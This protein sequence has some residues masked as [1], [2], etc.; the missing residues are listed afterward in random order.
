MST[1][2]YTAAKGKNTLTCDVVI[3]GS[4]PGGAAAARTLAEGG[5]KVIVLEEGPAK[6]NF[7]P[8][9]QHTMRYHM[10]E[11][12]QMLAQGDLIF[13]V[14]AG[15]GVGG[16]SL[17]NSAICWR[18]PD[19]V[20]R[21]WIP[22]LNGDDRYSPEHLA[23]IYEELEALLGIADTPEE[24]WGENNAIVI[25][26]ANALGLN[27]RPLKRNTPGCVG[28]GICN[29]GCPSGGKA[30]VDRNLI[31]MAIAAGAI[32][33]GDVKV[34]HLL[35][36]D[37]KMKGVSGTVRN[38]DSEEVVGELTILADIVIVAAG[39]IGS[40]RLFHHTGMAHHLGPACGQNLHLHPGNAVFGLCDHEVHMW[41]GATQGAYF[42][43]PELPEILPHTISLDPGALLLAMGGIGAQAKEMM[44]LLPRM[45]GCLVMVTDKGSGSVGSTNDGRASITYWWDEDDIRL[46]KLG[47]L[48][49]AEVLVAGGAKRLLVP[50]HG[51]GWV[52]S[53]DELRE[54]MADKGLRDFL[55]MYS[56]HPTGTCHMGVDPET[57]VVRPDG[58][59]HHIEGLYI[60]DSSLFPSALGVNP[61]LT[62]MAMATVIAKGILANG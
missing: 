11:K 52:D 1:Q 59:A 54:K 18:A 40:P 21:G 6:P 14:A 15:R 5:K 41:K 10:Q 12:G 39:G 29:F 34:D 42:K 45:C 13:P 30:S 36:E 33:Q 60:A 32:V 8:N 20:L 28:C 48:R 22:E 24:V 44:A 27:G 55:V 4:G 46:T 35:Y 62:T 61:Q 19:A 37:G 17:I 23:P 57:S 3:V 51:V 56:S 50:I 49:T 58:R 9:Q 38:P 47:M 25:R 26:G 53:V 2:D 16:G 7:R 31:P 43:D